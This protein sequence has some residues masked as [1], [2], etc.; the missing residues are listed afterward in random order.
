VA[1][2]GEDARLD[3]QSIG[4]IK[5]QT[6]NLRI[7]A[8]RKRNTDVEFWTLLQKLHNNIALD[9]VRNEYALHTKLHAWLVNDVRKTDLEAFNNKVYAE[10]FLT[11]ATDPWLGLLSTDTYVALENSGVEKLP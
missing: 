11:P 4:L 8:D 2:R 1:D 9:T 7:G 10:L 5:R 3:A 6:Q